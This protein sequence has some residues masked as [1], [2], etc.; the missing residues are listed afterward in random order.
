MIKFENLAK[1]VRFNIKR[2]AKCHGYIRVRN[3]VD[4][5]DEKRTHNFVKSDHF[6]EDICNILC[7]YTQT[8]LQKCLRDLL[9]V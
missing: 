5:G 8:A 3:L 4:S 1:L 2:V 9:N 6:W 7:V